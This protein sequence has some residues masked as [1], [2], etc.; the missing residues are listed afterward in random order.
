MT[1]LYENKMSF[2]NGMSLSL[3]YEGRQ[4]RLFIFQLL[5]RVFMKSV[6]GYKDTTSKRNIHE[7]S[8]QGLIFPLIR[9]SIGL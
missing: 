4:S 3:M 6:L 8:Q 7:K 2:A 1:F 5:K 9:R